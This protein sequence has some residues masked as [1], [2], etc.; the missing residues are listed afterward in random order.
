MLLS[1]YSS[2]IIIVIRQK[3]QKNVPQE[4]TTF[5]RAGIRTEPETAN[6]TEPKQE[7]VR[8]SATVR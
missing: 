3:M 6:I 7:R 2:D 8:E 5:S 1:S 4:R